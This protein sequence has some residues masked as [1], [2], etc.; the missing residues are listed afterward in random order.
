MYTAHS[1]VFAYGACVYE[2]LT[3]KLPYAQYEDPQVAYMLPKGLLRLSVEGHE[4]RGGPTLVQ[5]MERCVS[6][7]PN[8]RPT[9]HEVKYMGALSDTMS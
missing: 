8:Q 5:L 4:S 2:L 7:E 9:F 1:D 3:S 6:F